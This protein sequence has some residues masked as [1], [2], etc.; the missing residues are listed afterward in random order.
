MKTPG[1]DRPG[2]F[3]AD[4]FSRVLRS[5]DLVVHTGA[6]NVG[7]ERYV[8]VHKPGAAVQTAVE[9]AEID[10]KIFD[11]GRPILGDCTLKPAAERPAGIGG[12]CRGKARCRGADIAERR[13]AGDKGH[14]AIGGIA[15]AAANRR[16]PSVAG[17][18][19]ER[20]TIVRAVDVGPIDVT[21]DAEHRAAPLIIV[22]DGAA[23]EAA[24]NVAVAGRVP[25]RIAECAAA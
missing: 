8:V 1:L 10:I 11:L 16:Q 9:L 4:K 18:T 5:V 6:Q 23:D 13:T 21:F 2:A 7:V 25:A 19:A 17:L 22:A 3:D 20:A 12:T 15:E 14:E 24:R